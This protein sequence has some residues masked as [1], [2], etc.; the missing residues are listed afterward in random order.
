MWNSW[1]PLH[2]CSGRT[3]WQFFAQNTNMSRNSA[4]EYT[5]LSVYEQEGQHVDLPKPKDLVIILCLYS[6]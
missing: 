5:F 4:D 1:I 2:D 6:F 3:I